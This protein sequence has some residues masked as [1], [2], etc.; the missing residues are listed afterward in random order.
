MVVPEGVDN[1]QVVVAVELGADRA[2]VQCLEVGQHHRL[3]SGS[4][5]LGPGPY[6]LPELLHGYAAEHRGRHL[7]SGFR[8]AGISGRRLDHTAVD[9]AKAAN[10]LRVGR[11]QFQ[12]NVPS[13]RVA[14]H[15][16]VLQA[17]GFDEARSIAA[18]AG[19]I[20]AV[21]RLGAV[22]VASLVHGDN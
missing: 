13:P 18:H 17:L 16:G 10:Q 20:V 15:D 3:E 22:S 12:R 11:R 9:E 8:R 14:D 5:F 2:V 7:L 1:S 4:Q 21:V 19:E 6:P